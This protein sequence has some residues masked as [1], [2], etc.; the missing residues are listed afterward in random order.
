M[1]IFWKGENYY[2]L[3]VWY[4]TYIQ[5]HLKKIIMLVK[6]DFKITFISKNSS[7]NPYF[8][9]KSFG[10]LSCALLLFLKLIYSAGNERY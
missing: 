2:G 9:E 1:Y 6:Y 5:I 7:I 10:E 8:W 4:L 3:L